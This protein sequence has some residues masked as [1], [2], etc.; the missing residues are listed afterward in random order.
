M[1]SEV[2]HNYVP[3]PDGPHVVRNS[4]V[5]KMAKAV[6]EDFHAIP[7]MGD[8]PWDELSRRGK[9]LFIME[10]EYALRS[11]GFSIEGEGS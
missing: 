11:G 8:L 5:E 3:N 10:I 7:D 1:V 4:T 9:F 2:T 6:Y